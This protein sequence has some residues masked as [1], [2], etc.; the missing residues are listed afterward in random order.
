[1]R[2]FALVFFVAVTASCTELPDVAPPVDNGT[3]DYPD[4]VPLGSITRDEAAIAAN[5][6]DVEA[7]VANRLAGL[8]ARA[9]ELRTVQFD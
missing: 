2:Q 8:R 5:A 7:D 6:V 1:M 9:A 3:I 4:L